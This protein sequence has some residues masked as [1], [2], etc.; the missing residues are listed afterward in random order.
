MAPKSPSSL[1]F[2]PSFYISGSQPVVS[3]P[4]VVHRGLPGGPQ[5]SPNIY[6]ILRKKYKKYAKRKMCE[7]LEFVFDVSQ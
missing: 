6:L 1:S 3:G 2:S 5:A 4:P 7:V